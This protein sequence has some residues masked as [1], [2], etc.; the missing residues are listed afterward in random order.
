[1]VQLN[2]NSIEKINLKI[3]KIFNNNNWNFNFIKNI[4]FLWQHNSN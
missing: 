2:K 3:N 1:M 4:I